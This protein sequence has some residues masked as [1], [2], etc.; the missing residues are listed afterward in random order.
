MKSKVNRRLFLK[1]LRAALIASSCVSVLKAFDHTRDDDCPGGGP[2]YDVCNPAMNDPDSCPGEL[3]PTDECVTGEQ[4]ED[5][6]DSG[7]ADADVCNPNIKRADQCSSGNAADDNCSE[8]EFDPDQCYSG[9]SPDPDACPPDGGIAEGDNC[10]GGSM[11]VDNCGADGKG[12]ECSPEQAWDI[13]YGEDRCNEE[14]EDGCVV[15][16]D[17]CNNGTNTALGTGDDDICGRG[18]GFGPEGGDTCIDGSPEQ[19][20]CGT[21]K[22]DPDLCIVSALSDNGDFCDPSAEYPSDDN[23]FKGLPTS[24]ECKPEVGD[25]DECPNGQ[26]PEDECRSFTALD[27]ICLP[28]YEGSDRCGP[29][30]IPSDECFGMQDLCNNRNQDVVE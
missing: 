13:Y 12:E 15:T 8:T 9:V 10:P 22:G 2:E 19:D 11:A 3:P 14:I 23:C 4:T 29:T 18:L 7:K 16:P 17:V 5:Y 27:D 30:I 24:D 6:C 21:I 25:S 20:E 26:S 28:E 1:E